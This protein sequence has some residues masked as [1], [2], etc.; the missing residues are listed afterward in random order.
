MKTIKDIKLTVVGR[1]GIL[2]G[3]GGAVER[4]YIVRI[5]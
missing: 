5:H 4:E 3:M 2:G 1:W